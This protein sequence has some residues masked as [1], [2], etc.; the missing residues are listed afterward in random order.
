[1][2]SVIY[3]AGVISLFNC[4]AKLTIRKFNLHK[5]LR[6]YAAGIDMSLHRFNINFTI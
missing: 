3:I 5:R 4:I 1:M 6:F 2:T